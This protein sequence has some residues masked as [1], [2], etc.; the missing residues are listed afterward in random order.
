MALAAAVAVVAVIGWRWQ[1]QLRAQV[2]EAASDPSLRLA[3]AGG[4]LRGGRAAA[5]GRP[6]GGRAAGGRA[7]RCDAYVR[8]V[9][10]SGGDVARARAIA[11]GF[12]AHS[13]DLDRVAAHLPR[14]P[15]SVIR[16][17][18]GPA[19][20]LA[21]FDDASPRPPCGTPRARFAAGPRGVS[22]CEGTAGQGAKGTE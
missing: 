19:D 16:A 21:V 10:A 5:E 15:S 6:G 1:G 22:V 7:R 20:L 13:P 18:S 12:A 8:K 2:R 3:V 11:A 14:P 4:A 9:A 17:G